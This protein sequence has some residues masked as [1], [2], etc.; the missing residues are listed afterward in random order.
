MALTRATGISE[1]GGQLFDFRFP[2]MSLNEP[3]LGPGHGVDRMDHVGG[4][5]D[6]PGLFGNR[7]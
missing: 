6:H 2:A 4:D 5:A 7:P 3:L 1:Q